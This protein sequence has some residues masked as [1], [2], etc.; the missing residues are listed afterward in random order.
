MPS[1]ISMEEFLALESQHG[2]NKNA[3]VIST[4]EFLDLQGDSNIEPTLGES[5]FNLEDYTP[6]EPQLLIDIGDQTLTLD[7]VKELAGDTPVNT[8][9]K[10]NN[11]IIRHD[12][13]HTLPEVK[14]TPI[15]EQTANR[16]DELINAEIEGI[17]S[18]VYE[19]TSTRE[20]STKKK[21]IDFS[22]KDV[23][24][25]EDEKYLLKHVN[26]PLTGLEDVKDPN[27]PYGP[28]IGVKR[29]N[30]NLKGNESITSIE[31]KNTAFKIWEQLKSE[32]EYIGGFQEDGFNYKTYQKT[33]QEL[34]DWALEYQSEMNWED[35]LAMDDFINAYRSKMEE[36]WIREGEN[37]KE[38]LYN[39]S[40]I[41][42]IINDRFK[43]LI[44]NKG[45]EEERGELIP[46]NWERAGIIPSALY[47]FAKYTIPS[48]LAN[49]RVAING[50][51][52]YNISEKLK[53]G[54]EKG[55]TD[56]TKGFI[57][58]VGDQ[59]TFREAKGFNVIGMK[60][61]KAITW[62]EAQV[63]L[64]AEV[65]RYGYVVME[66]LAKS[67]EYQE[68]LSILGTPE[69]LDENWNW[70]LDS[71]G[72]KKLLGTQLG[73]MALG[74]LSFGGSTFMQELGQMS[75]QLI[76]EKSV[77]MMEG[78]PFKV[79]NKKGELVDSDFQNFSEKEVEYLMKKF[80]K[81][82]VEEQNQL[83]IKVLKGGH[84]PF[85]KLYASAARSG[86]LD[87]IGNWFVIGKA[88]SKM[89]PKGLVN[90]FMTKHLGKY[91]ATGTALAGRV[92]VG[93]LGEM[94]TEG[95]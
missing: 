69:L 43:S 18:K 21:T 33:K 30:T 9:I 84:I 56:K 94:L 70:N 77:M 93:T 79:K 29:T 49:D 85:D 55:W 22:Q 46:D 25:S 24:L 8:Y 19:G 37:D 1:N 58:L 95:L 73:Q 27:N 67:K 35:P 14:V 59:L 26:N 34:N 81:L 17:L 3:N 89:V 47:E 74:T 38:Y 88:G 52:I 87:L 6:S 60:K 2:S 20:L 7:Q 92:T 23:D 40:I 15:Y 16:A 86:G 48:A 75:Q 78:I 51:K 76:L 54:R 53:E 10:E 61:V 44:I 82:S 45:V 57:G 41:E 72:Y 80:N 4:D 90:T 11:G 5:G 66:N 12:R 36:L 42:N 63:E 32:N 50:E 65:D 62:G 31:L 28:P 83:A 13:E 91:Y 71:D 64:N 39:A 68:K